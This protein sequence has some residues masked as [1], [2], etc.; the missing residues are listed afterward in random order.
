MKT[1]PIFFLALIGLILFFMFN[2]K[3]SAEETGITALPN[4]SSSSFSPD[5]GK[6]EKLVSNMGPVTL[7]G[8][9]TVSPYPVFTVVGAGSEIL[10]SKV[11][12]TKATALNSGYEIPKQTIIA[13]SQ[14]LIDTSNYIKSNPVRAAVLPNFILPTKAAASFVSHTIQ[15]I[16]SKPVS[17]IRKRLRKI[18]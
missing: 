17:S 10:E 5:L 11:G 13:G 14:A 7:P 1:L 15:N 8:L 2:R 9:G 6:F 3:A 16:A 4:D 12:V 18:F